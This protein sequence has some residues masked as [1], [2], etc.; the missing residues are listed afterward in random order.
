[1]QVILASWT[2]TTTTVTGVFEIIIILFE[3]LFKEMI[4]ELNKFI[5]DN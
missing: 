4:L 1:M 2:K 3:S 5:G